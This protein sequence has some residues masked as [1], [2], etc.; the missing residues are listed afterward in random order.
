[1]VVGT[2]VGG[3]G[4]LDLLAAAPRS[5]RPCAAASSSRSASA[6]ACASSWAL[7]FAASLTTSWRVRGCGLCGQLPGRTAARR[8]RLRV[9]GVAERRP[10][11]HVVQLAQHSTAAR[12]GIGLASWT[13]RLPSL[14]IRFSFWPIPTPTL[15]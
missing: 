13:A 6:L 14:R 1:M 5:R 4:G 11:H 12:G 10:H 3:L 9:G 8:H 15:A 7:N 2:G